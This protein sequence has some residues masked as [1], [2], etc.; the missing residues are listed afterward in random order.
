MSRYSALLFVLLTGVANADVL[1]HQNG[2]L[3]RIFHQLFAA[4]HLPLTVLLVVA[5]IVLVRR[6]RAATRKS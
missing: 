2:L 5:G 3:E 1:D 6:L 4:H